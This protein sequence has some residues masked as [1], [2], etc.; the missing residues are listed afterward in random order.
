MGSGQVN[1]TGHH[2]TERVAPATAPQARLEMLLKACQFA[3]ACKPKR[4]KLALVA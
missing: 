3:N 2:W 4:P 1:V